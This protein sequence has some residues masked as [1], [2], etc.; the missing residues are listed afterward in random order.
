MKIH[1]FTI[2]AHDPSHVSQVLAGLLG[3]RITPLPHSGGSY[4]VHAGDPGTAIEVWPASLRAAPGDAELAPSILPL[5]ECWPHHAYLTSD[6][7]DCDTI[8][9]TFARE[10]W[11][12]EKVHN[13]PAQGGFNLVRGWI[14]NHAAIELGG[15]E[16]RTQYEEFFV[17]AAS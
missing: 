2:P 6:A 10:G 3:A 16:M 4:L 14:E 11:R 15:R 17:K 9:A 5:P 1:H 13:G 8:L 7:C 12:A